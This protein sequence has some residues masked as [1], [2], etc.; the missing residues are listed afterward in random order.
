[1]IVGDRAD[2][3][4][5][6]RGLEALNK[7][8]RC[9][10]GKLLAEWPEDVFITGKGVESLPLSEPAKAFLIY[11]QMKR[12]SPSF[13]AK[14]FDTN[15]ADVFSKAAN[16]GVCNRLSSYWWQGNDDP[17]AILHLQGE[18]SVEDT[19]EPWCGAYDVEVVGCSPFGVVEGVLDP[20]GTE[21]EDEGSAP[22]ISFKIDA[23]D[24]KSLPTL[25]LTWP[26]APMTRAEKK[27]R[28][29]YFK[30]CHAHRKRFEAKNLKGLS[31]GEV[32]ERTR[33]NL[34][35]LAGEVAWELG[36]GEVQVSG[37]LFDEETVP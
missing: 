4:F 33:D 14:S 20:K 35:R 36:P 16:Q 19:V 30:L 21:G 1:M 28:D 27:Y 6:A 24:E 2:F 22:A 3:E 29:T 12:I 25:S 37:K 5:V 31:A 26:G 7:N 15:L 34:N 18:A 17:D 8:D 32:G 10:V 23:R 11:Q 13:V 9:T